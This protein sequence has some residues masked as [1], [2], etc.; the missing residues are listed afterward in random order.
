MGFGSVFGLLA[1][2]LIGWGAFNLFNSN[3]NRDHS[4]SPGNTPGRY[5]DALDILKQRYARGEISQIEYERMR[6]DL[7]NS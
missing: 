7:G 2:L 5:S 3:R 6:Q 1:L 4:F